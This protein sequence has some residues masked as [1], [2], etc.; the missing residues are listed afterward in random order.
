MLSYLGEKSLGG[1]DGELKEYTVGVEA[2]GKPADYS[3]QSDASVRVQ[4][5]KLRQKLEEY[6]RTEGAGDP[7]E[8]KFPK[9]GFHLTFQPA[10]V[11][12]SATPPS[13][14]IAPPAPSSV[15]RKWQ[16]C[17]LVL[18]VLFAA[19]AGLA[20]KWRSQLAAA[21]RAPLAEWEAQAW[22]PEMAAVWQP[23]LDSNRPVLLSLGTPMFAR[24][25]SVFVRDTALNEWDEAR[26]SPRLQELAKLFGGREPTP[27]YTYTGVGEATAAILLYKSFLAGRREP[28]LKHGHRLSWEDIANNNLIFVGSSKY[29]RHLRDLPVSREFVIESGE[30]VNLRPRDGEGAAY[31]KR[32][33]PD[34][35]VVECH[36]LISRFPG[37]H[38]RGE[39]TV[40]ESPT[41]EGAWAAALYLTSAEHVKDLVGRLRGDS[42][43]LPQ[44][45][46]AVIRAKLNSQ[47]PVQ[48]SYVTH[49]A[50]PEPASQSARQGQ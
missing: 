47:V 30:I 12:P 29:N 15:A 44:A 49:R 50:L 13:V 40:I 31:G 39:I 37:L 16:L 9:G 3:P 2:F 38:G 11:K 41:S 14:E 19:A 6:Y 1:T 33:G 20:V 42:G 22:T 46:Q 10:E 26:Q 25:E 43:Q 35:G 32:R 48:I 21:E 4:A 23:Y 45:F 5:S 28:Q 8:I 27:A 24:Y 18:L 7:V 36:A 17:S 34:R